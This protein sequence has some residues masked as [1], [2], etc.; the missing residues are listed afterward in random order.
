MTRRLERR[1][2]HFLCEPK[3]Q[4]S[5]NQFRP[6]KLHHAAHLQPISLFYIEYIFTFFSRT[7]HY[8]PPTFYDGSM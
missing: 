2:G 8:T 5:K 3:R 4:R 1:I 6:A 7:P